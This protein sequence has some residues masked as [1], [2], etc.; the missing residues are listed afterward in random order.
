MSCASFIKMQCTCMFIY[1]IYYLAATCVDVYTHITFLGTFYYD[2][3]RNFEIQQ[4]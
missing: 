2:A 3:W 4:A 1:M